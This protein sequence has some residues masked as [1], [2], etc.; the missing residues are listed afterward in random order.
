MKTT[1]LQKIKWFHDNVDELG[2]T[3]DYYLYLY[4]IENY[5][6][7]SLWSRLK[8]TRHT[9]SYKNVHKTIKS[10]KK[11][12]MLEPDGRHGARQA[13]HYKL[14]DKGLE[15]TKMIIKYY[16]IFSGEEEEE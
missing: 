5:S 10:L 13:I 12:G 15:R 6:A 11:L 9:I 14:T 3:Q 16:G 7:Y 4:G 1:T 8:R 2:L